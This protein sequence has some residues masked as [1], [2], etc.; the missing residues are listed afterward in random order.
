MMPQLRQSFPGLPSKVCPLYTDQP[1]QPVKT[2]VGVVV[3]LL[4]EV[5]QSAEIFSK[6]F[7][8]VETYSRLL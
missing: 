2:I 4:G 7:T 8:A 5:I 1:E 3:D 6:I